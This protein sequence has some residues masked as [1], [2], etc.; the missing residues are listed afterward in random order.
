L[1]LLLQIVVFL[2]VAA[3][4]GFV[5]GWLL[6]GAR[7]EHERRATAPRQSGGEA[8]LAE[9]RDRLQTELRAARDAQAQLEASAAET[10]KL[11]DARASRVREL[12]QADAGSRQ[13][14]ARLEDELK[15]I[16]A[17]TEGEASPQRA[18]AAAATPQTLAEMSAEGAVGTPPPALAAP[19]GAPDDLKKIN[20]I[21]PGIE[22]I[23]HEVGIY[24]FRQIAQFTPD[25]VAWLNQRLRFKGRIEREDWIGQARKLAAGERTD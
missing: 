23:L 13:Q 11:A 7:M 8:A 16:K 21:G 14:I 3:A 19:E 4:L 5:I 10:Q 20:G 2:L 9:E 24:H 1:S 18:R 22:K 25:N 15:S 12:E 17:T 6:R